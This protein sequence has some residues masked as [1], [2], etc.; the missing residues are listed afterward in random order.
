MTLP[1]GLHEHATRITEPGIYNDLPG[2]IYHQQHDWLSWSGMKNLI[3]PKTPAHFKATW[4]VRRPEK[5]AFDLG[6][7]AH[8]LVLGE[9]D[10]YAVV[11]GKDGDATD[12]RTNAAKEHRDA[13]YADGLVPILRHE[14][15]AAIAMADAVPHTP[16]PRACSPRVRLRCRCSGWTTRPA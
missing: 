10:Q 3:P 15:E 1:P 14:L 12:Y 7:V 4:G 13:L 8:T 16:K 9:G 6:H 2:H 11:Q 5:R